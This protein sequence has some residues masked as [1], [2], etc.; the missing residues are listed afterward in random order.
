MNIEKIKQL[1]ELTKLLDNES[2]EK[3]TSS[4]YDS[5]MNKKVIIR[6]YS[7]GVHYGILN[8][9]DNDTV[10]LL[11]ARRIHYWNGANS[12]TDIALGGISDKV[13]SR[14]TKK[15]PSIILQ[16]VIEIIECTEVA[17]KDLDN[18]PEWTLL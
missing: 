18:F 6:T 1:I 16:N 7:A 14:I 10:E 13:N 8:K 9:V 4:I 17:I 2:S 3:K 15:L 11:K 12:L 5:V